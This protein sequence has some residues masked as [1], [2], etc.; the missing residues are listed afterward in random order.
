MPRWNFRT[1]VEDRE[2]QR[3]LDARLRIKLGLPPVDQTRYE[4]MP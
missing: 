2:R 4:T 3:A 1:T